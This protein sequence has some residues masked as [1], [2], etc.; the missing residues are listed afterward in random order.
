MTRAALP[1]SLSPAG[2]ALMTNAS[3]LL[4]VIKGQTQTLGST[5]FRRS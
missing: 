2:L 4:K 5:N 3:L 1:L